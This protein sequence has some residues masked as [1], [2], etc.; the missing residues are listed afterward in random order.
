[1]GRCGQCQ[2]DWGCRCVVLIGPS[3][4]GSPGLPSVA[5]P[6]LGKAP[7]AQG[8][9]ASIFAKCERQGQPEYLPERRSFRIG[10]HSTTIY[11]ELAYWTLLE[12]IA[13]AEGVS[14]TCLVSA[15]YAH[16]ETANARNMAS[17]LRVLCLRYLAV[18]ENLRAAQ[19]GFAA[20]PQAMPVGDA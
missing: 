19:P 5:D 6:Q 2:A 8:V 20:K 15:I 1:M 9:L 7:P 16:C 10:G 12:A 3:R 4:D 17:C 18:D 14:V 11:L 13:R